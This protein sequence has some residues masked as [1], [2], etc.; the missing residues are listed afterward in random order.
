MYVDTLTR[1]IVAEIFKVDKSWMHFPCNH[2]WLLYFQARSVL[3]GASQL[4]RHNRVWEICD[5]TYLRLSI[6]AECRWILSHTSTLIW[7]KWP[8]ELPLLSYKP[9]CNWASIYRNVWPLCVTFLSTDCV[10][11]I[12]SGKHISLGTDC[13]CK[14]ASFFLHLKISKWLKCDFLCVCVC[15]TW[16]KNWVGFCVQVLCIM[17]SWMFTD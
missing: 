7:K 14:C 10:G 8:Q 6:A 4:C 17:G 16:T 3:S 13:L 15:Y 12:W 2:R 11:I 9:I 5:S 1:K